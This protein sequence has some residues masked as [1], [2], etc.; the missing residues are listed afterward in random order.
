MSEEINKPTDLLTTGIWCP[1]GIS[2][3]EFDLIPQ[4]KQDNI[5]MN[6]LFW[7]TLTLGTILGLITL[8][9][10]MPESDLIIALMISSVAIV[11]CLNIIALCGCWWA[12]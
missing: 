2:L 7:I 12:I 11:G 8:F 6:K 1:I 4:R 10:T 3:E 9:G 5:D